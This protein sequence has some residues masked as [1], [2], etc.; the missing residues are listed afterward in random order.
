MSNF[1]LFKAAVATK[2]QQLS[3]HELFRTN[4][5]GDDIWTSYLAGFP[6]GSNPIY[7]KRTEHDCSC[8]RQFIKKLGNVVAIIDDKVASIWDVDVADPV[9]Q[10]VASR[11]RQTVQGSDLVDRFL[12]YETT[13]GTDK[14]FDDSLSGVTT[15]EHFFVNVPCGKRGAKN[16]V[17]VK[18]DLPTKLGEARTTRD[19]LLRGLEEITLGSVDTVLE[20]I[21]QNSLYRGEENLGVLR[22]FRELKVKFD[23][24]EVEE[25]LA[26]LTDEASSE[27]AD[28][29][30]H[31]RDTVVWSQTVEVS[32]AISRLRNTAVGTLL[33]DLSEGLEL[34]EAV[35]KFEAMVAPANY[36]RPTALV[37]KAMIADAKKTLDEL[38]LTS[39]LDRRYATLTDLTVDRVLF[40]D[41]SARQ[42]LTGDVFSELS[43]AAPERPRSLDKIETIAIDKFLRDVLPRSTTV[44]LLL[45][46]RHAG[47]FASLIAPT[48]P[49]ALPLFKW[50]NP[51]SW[52]YQGDFAD[53]VKERVKRAGGNV[54]ADVC[55]RLGWYNYDDLDLHMIEPRSRSAGRSTSGGYE[56]YYGNK[57]ALSPNGGTLDVDM[58]AGGGHTREPVENIFYASDSTMSMGVY[59]L[60]VHQYDKRVG[61]DPGFEVEIDVRG[62]VTRFVYDK[63]LRTGE[64]VMIAQITVAGTAIVVHN[65]LPVATST[66]VS[67]EV[68][69]LH[70]ENF[71]RVNLV[72][73]SPNYWNA[74]G[75]G[76]KHYLFML[77]GCRNDGTARGFY[78]EFLTN[79]LAKHRRV[80]ELVGS[81]VRAAE[82]VDQLS[83]LGFSST[84][85][86]HAILRVT[87]AMTRTLRV[88]F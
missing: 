80:L 34:T 1:H 84:R 50:D 61:A 88:E 62:T 75:V 63:P 77:D 27:V 44:E 86:D 70:T 22:A 65:L 67:R 33:T 51:F 43:A 32:G 54:V 36:R 69:G 57:G 45:E 8:C 35:R 85:R 59:H 73:L 25:L 37:T 66:T 64:H 39:A 38:G 58:N 29:R 17:C 24:F 11:L 53:S 74:P 13:V 55:C 42:T 76:N 6:E 4:V 3:Q 7:R 46:D 21:S 60:F 71:H 10:A 82:S 18:A 19:V 56:I 12:H 40:A 72:T 16:F 52:S 23:A 15:W 48:D 87:G 5:S 26:T 28:T 79:D 14:N 49:T 41:R 83:G 9:Y 68:W 78:N 2:F 20:L 31:D 30:L 81:K 47:K